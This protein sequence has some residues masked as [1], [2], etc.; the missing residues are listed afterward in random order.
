ML[1]NEKDDI[2]CL[3][4]NDSWHKSNVVTIMVYRPGFILLLVCFGC[5]AVLAQQASLG[6]SKFNFEQISVNEGLVDQF[7]LSIEQDKKGYMWFGT[8]NGLCRYDGYEMKV[9]QHDP[10]DST[11]LSD[12][13]IESLYVD[14]AGILWIGTGRGG[15]NRFDEASDSFIHYQYDPDDPTSL[16]SPPVEY[17]SASTGQIK[18][19][20]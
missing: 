14:R 20:F 15:L 5:D 18:S 4:N 3:L 2:F 9:Y 12:N 19:I 11:S 13:V 17:G 7:V 16:F 8:I 1:D 10:Q 6:D